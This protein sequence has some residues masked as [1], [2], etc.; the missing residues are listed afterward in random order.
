MFFSNTVQNQTLKKSCRF[1]NNFQNL[2]LWTSTQWFFYWHLSTWAEFMFIFDKRKEFH[3]PGHIQC[4]YRTP[5][6]S[7]CNAEC[8]FWHRR[9]TLALSPPSHFGLNGWGVTQHIMVWRDVRYGGLHWTAM[10]L[11]RFY[12]NPECKLWI[13]VITPD[14][15]PGDENCFQLYEG[16]LRGVLRKMKRL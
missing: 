13:T 15:Y 6:A 16:L 11:N 10:F 14:V 9:L 8:T 7:Y 4:C 2:K 1:N 12:E 3:I 5:F